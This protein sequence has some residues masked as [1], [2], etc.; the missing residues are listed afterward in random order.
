[1]TDFQTILKLSYAIPA[2]IC[3][4]FY[5]VE[6]YQKVR[7]D[8]QLKRKGELYYPSVEVG[9]VAVR[10]GISIFP[11]VNLLFVLFEFAPRMFVKT[12]IKIKLLLERPLV[13]PNERQRTLY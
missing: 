10:L 12:I 7:S 9:D 3:L 4:M 6:I 13:K 2:L 8:L 5:I 11:I 1:M